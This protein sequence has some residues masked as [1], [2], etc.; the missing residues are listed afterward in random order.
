MTIMKTIEQ[1]SDFLQLNFFH[2]VAGTQ[3]SMQLQDC[4]KVLSDEDS[5]VE[6]KYEALALISE[7]KPFY[8][9]LFRL[10][11]VTEKKCLQNWNIEHVI[12]YNY[13]NV[14]LPYLCSLF[15]PITRFEQFQ[16]LD[17]DN[18][19]ISLLQMEKLIRLVLTHDEIQLVELVDAKRNEIQQ[20][21]N[22]YFEHNLV[23]DMLLDLRKAIQKL[24][25]EEKTLDQY[26]AK[27]REWCVKHNVIAIG[28][29]HQPEYE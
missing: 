14:H 3:M 10:G 27:Y 11:I 12:G 1:R 28:F 25:D 29:M 15:C 19:E 18:D 9:M 5:S 26:L 8:N 7:N 4:M 13:F 17:S 6:Q 24:P 2:V 20:A 21:G 22:S 16:S 23:K